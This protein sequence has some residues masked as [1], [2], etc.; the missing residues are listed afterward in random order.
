[1]KVYNI[2]KYLCSVECFQKNCCSIKCC[3]NACVTIS[4]KKNNNSVSIDDEWNDM[5]KDDNLYVIENESSDDESS[6]DGSYNMQ[7]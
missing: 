6:D 2:I 1:M 5:L 3:D 7:V 4:C